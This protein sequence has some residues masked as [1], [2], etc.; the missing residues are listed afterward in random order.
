MKKT[1]LLMHLLTLLVAV[2]VFKS[3]QKQGT[4][5]TIF[6]FKLQ[7]SIDLLEFIKHS[8]LVYYKSKSI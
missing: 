1:E 2:I 6:P 7:V 4:I 8:K 5:R 3:L